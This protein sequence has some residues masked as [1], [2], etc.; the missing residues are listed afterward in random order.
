MVYVPTPNDVVEKMLEM[1]Q[2]KKGDVVYDLGCG[3]GRIVVA[4]AKKGAK[5]SGYDIAHERVEEAK[6]NVKKNKVE[7]SASIFEK[8]IFE[9]DLSPANVVT[10][11]PPAAAEREADPA[12]GETQA[13]LAD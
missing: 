2:V 1:A 9:L 11:Y 3:D 5:A 8:D 13:G 7:K 10:L 12:V 4:A 6:A